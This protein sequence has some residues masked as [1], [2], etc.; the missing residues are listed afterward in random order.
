MT[1]CVDD[2]IFVEVS[3]DSTTQVADE[4]SSHFQLKKQGK[5]LIVLGIEME[6][7]MSLK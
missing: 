6:Y 5:E 2:M 1:L 7:K 4:L 3:A